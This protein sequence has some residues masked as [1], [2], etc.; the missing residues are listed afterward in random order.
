[1]VLGGVKEETTNTEVAET[2]GEEGLP[3]TSSFSYDWSNR[4]YPSYGG[5]SLTMDPSMDPTWSIINAVINIFSRAF[6]LTVFPT[7]WWAVDLVYLA[8]EPDIFRLRETVT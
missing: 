1:M 8:F 6:L 2:D 5:S 3:T 4:L 7:T